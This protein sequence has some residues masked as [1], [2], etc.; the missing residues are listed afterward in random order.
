MWAQGRWRHSP[1]KTGSRGEHL[2][3][4]EWKEVEDFR[5]QGVLGSNIGS[6][7]EGVEIPTWN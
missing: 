5:V 6:R 4:V 1:Q 3:A 2:G 7:I